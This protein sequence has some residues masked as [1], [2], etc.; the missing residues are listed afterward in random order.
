MA[1]SWTTND[2]FII[3]HR[4]AEKNI[5]PLSNNSFTNYSIRIFVMCFR[6]IRALLKH[7]QTDQVTQTDLP[8]DQSLE[9]ASSRHSCPTRQ[10]KQTTPNA[11]FLISRYG[12]RIQV[13]FEA[14]DRLSFLTKKEEKRVYSDNDEDT[15]S[16]WRLR[17]RPNG[18][19]LYALHIVND[20]YFDS[21][22]LLK[23]DTESRIT[24]LLQRH[25]RCRRAQ[26]LP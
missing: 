10:A 21:G 16:F 26:H 25:H 5:Q 3:I 17:F 23:K 4:Y 7:H 1:N 6:F 15:K 20:T 12:S 11:L 14:G 24:Y 18:G 19:Q 8:M 2:I 9:R 22:A 13:G